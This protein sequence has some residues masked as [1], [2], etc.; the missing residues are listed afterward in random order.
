MEIKL[1]GLA[2]GTRP[3]SIVAPKIPWYSFPGY[4][5][6]GP[7]AGALFNVLLGTLLLSLFLK[8]AA[9]FE[10]RGARSWWKL[11]VVN[12]IRYTTVL[13]GASLLGELLFPRYYLLDFGAWNT[14]GPFLPDP[15]FLPYLWRAGVFFAASWVLSTVVTRFLVREVVPA[16]PRRPLALAAAHSTVVYACGFTSTLA[17]ACAILFLVSLATRENKGGASGGGV[18]GARAE[19]T[20]S[21]PGPA[22]EFCSGP[23]PNEGGSWN[24]RGLVECGTCPFCGSS[25][26]GAT[27]FC[28]NCGAPLKKRD[29][30]IP[31]ARPSR[32][33]WTVLGLLV[34]LL[35]FL[36]ASFT[37]YYYTEYRFMASTHTFEQGSDKV[38][39]TVGSLVPFYAVA[40]GAVASLVL[41]TLTRAEFRSII[42]HRSGPHF[43]AGGHRLSIEEV[44]ENENRCRIIDAVLED[45]GVHFNELARRCELTPGQ[46]KWHADV[47]RQYGV[48]RT[49]RVGQYLAFF[50]LVPRN[51]LGDVDL[52]LGKSRTTLRVLKAVEERPG[53]SPSE[54]ARELSLAKA[55]VKYHVDKLVATGLVSTTREGRTLKLAATTTGTGKTG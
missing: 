11:F 13:G 46:L 23:R 31:V 43:Q 34:A 29:P 24:Q 37:W 25:L 2:R 27:N 20:R 49:E 42:L 48:V 12:A 45:P 40:I 38:T 44:L 6:A 52:R 5:I 4:Y 53:V 17:P 21:R 8:L 54:V 14:V 35:A 26:S 15:H 3:S 36:V 18:G 55:T 30:P 51:P 19:R 50:P 33:Q 16:E 10:T 1:E 41:F 22:R 47:L 7:V 32:R 9:S 39:T 28:L